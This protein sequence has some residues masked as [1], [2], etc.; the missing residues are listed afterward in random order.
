MISAVGIVLTIALEVG[1]LPIIR[2]GFDQPAVFAPAKA[3][4]AVGGIDNPMV[5]A[6]L[7]PN[8]HF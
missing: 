3:G 8:I 4:S 1:I 6:L 7:M 2:K 5:C